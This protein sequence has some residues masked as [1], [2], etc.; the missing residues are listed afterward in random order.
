MFLTLEPV[1]EK[2]RLVLQ[3]NQLEMRLQTLEVRRT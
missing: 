3:L 1:S 2:N